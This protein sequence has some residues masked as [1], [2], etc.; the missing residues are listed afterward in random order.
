MR[1]YISIIVEPLL[2]TSVDDAI[3]F[4]YFLLEFEVYIIKRILPQK[5]LDI[6]LPRYQ[7]HCPKC[8]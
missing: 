7:H 3:Y 5:N 4:S 6:F 1:I 2:S 8:I